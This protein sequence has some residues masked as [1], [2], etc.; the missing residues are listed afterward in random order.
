MKLPEAMTEQEFTASMNSLMEKG[1]VTIGVN[2]DGEL[3]FIPTPLCQEI[4][5]ELVKEEAAN[6][7]TTNG[8]AANAGTQ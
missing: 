6:G 7:D 5:G 3:G 1:L 2:G 8:S 4:F